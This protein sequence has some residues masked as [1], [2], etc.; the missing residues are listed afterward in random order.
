MYF[1]YLFWIF[2]LAYVCER[3]VM[4]ACCVGDDHT[5]RTHFKGR[6]IWR[7]EAGRKRETFLP[8]SARGH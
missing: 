8:R 4:T 7:K 3:L 1:N 2:F 5:V 6:R